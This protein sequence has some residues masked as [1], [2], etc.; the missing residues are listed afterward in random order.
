MATMVRVTIHGT[1]TTF[2]LEKV[3]CWR[4]DTRQRLTIWIGDCSEVVEF[5]SGEDDPLYLWLVAHSQTVEEVG[6]PKPHNPP[7]ADS[8]G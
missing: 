1:I 2:D 6:A 4:Y 3:V 5:S 8:P 7:F